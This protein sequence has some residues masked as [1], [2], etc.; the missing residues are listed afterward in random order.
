[1]ETGCYQAHFQFH[2][3]RKNLFWTFIGALLVKSEMR[4][5]MLLNGY[6]RSTRSRRED[7]RMSLGTARDW[8]AGPRKK[9][10][11]MTIFFAI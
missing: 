1:M 9:N 4:G 11:C 8:R 5:P 2:Q 3:K 10:R 7:I 6:F